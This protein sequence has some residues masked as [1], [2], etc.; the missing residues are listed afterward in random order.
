MLD[1]LAHREPHLALD[2]EGL[3]G[4]RMRVGVDHRIGFPLTLEHLVASGSAVL[5][6]K[7]VEGLHRFCSSRRSV[8]GG[9]VRDS[10]A[11]SF[12]SSGVI[13]ILNESSDA[14]S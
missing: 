14:L 5:G 3:N 4:E 12:Q 10:A 2:D 1:A 9:G 7:A 11:I 13:L 6:G 8:A